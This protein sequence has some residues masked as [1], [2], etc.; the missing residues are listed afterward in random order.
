MFEND[1]KTIENKYHIKGEKFNPYIRMA[2]HGYE[3]DKTTGKD[4]GEITDGLKKL[5]D[6]IKDLP[7][8]QAK[9][10]AVKYVLENTR[11]DINE[12][13]WFVG[14]YSVNRLADRITSDRW[15]NEIF[16]CVIPETDALM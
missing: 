7:H 11:I 5:Y 12:H 2:Y 16:A 1:R 8:P 6:S 3:Y 14:F 15:Y 10:Y 13:D 9:A 4:D